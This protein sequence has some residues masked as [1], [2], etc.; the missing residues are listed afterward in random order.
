MEFSRGQGGPRLDLPGVPDPICIKT[1]TFRLPASGA[2]RVELLKQVE[3]LLKKRV[4]QRLPLNELGSP[5]Y[6]SSL[7]LVDKWD[8]GFRPIFNVK[9]L[10]LFLYCPHFKMETVRLVKAS[11]QKGDWAVTLDLSDAYLHVPIH[12]KSYKYLRM[13]VTPKLVYYFRALPFGLCTAPGVFTRIVESVAAFLRI[14]GLYV[15][16]Y[17]D[18]WLIRHENLP[19]LTNKIPMILGFLHSLGW[20]VN[21][22]KSNIKPRQSFEYLGV[23]FDTV[24]A[25]VRVA[26]HL[27]EKGILTAYEQFPLNMVTPRRLQQ[28]EGLFNSLADYLILGR[29]FLRPIQMWRHRNWQTNVLTL[30]V[31]L[32]V[33]PEL[34]RYLLP[35]RDRDWLM[36]GVALVTP[37]PDLFLF[38]DSSLVAWGAVLD[39]RQ[40]QSPWSLEDREKHINVLEL[41]AVLLALKHFLPFLSHKVVLLL[42]DNTTAVAYLRRQ[43]GTHSFELCLLSWKILH[44]CHQNGIL[45]QVRHIP[46]KKNVLA[47]ALT[48]SKPLL[49]EWTLNRSIFEKILLLVPT[50]SIDLFATRN[51]TQLPIFLSPFPDHRAR[52]VDA[53][54]AAWDFPG[55]LYAFP[56]TTLIPAVLRRIRKEKVLVLLIAPLWTK[57][58]WFTDLLDLSVTNALRLPVVPNLLS[59]HHWL[60]PSPDIF[61]YHAWMLSS[62]VMNRRDILRLLPNTWLHL[63]GLQPQNFTHQNG[64]LIPIGVKREVWILSVP[65]DLS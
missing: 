65:M 30:D 5:G 53:L 11:I 31:P 40:V 46:S 42:C 62:V 9:K 12:P 2:R 27:I 13:A 16:V 14:Q 39:D 59:Q 52:G 26:D 32:Q 21:R 33:T 3:T 22:K 20:E 63:C 50:L 48:R 61:H 28:I 58:P 29:L 7:F 6:Y 35:W 17:L 57:Q 19:F 38:S 60:H 47:D 24:K 54:S 51:N 45:L 4:I 15:N 18:D 44:L 49:T 36:K 23:Q 1:T 25:V 55:I 41:K 64:E 37:S 56:P 10:N 8:G 43:G 34:R